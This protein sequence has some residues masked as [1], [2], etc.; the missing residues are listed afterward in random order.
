LNLTTPSGWQK[1]AKTSA[2]ATVTTLH[3]MTL[4]SGRTLLFC[5]DH[6]DVLRQRMRSNRGRRR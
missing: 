1:A 6:L 3:W 2:I 4:H 5:A